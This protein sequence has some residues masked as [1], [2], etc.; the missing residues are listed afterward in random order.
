MITKLPTLTKEFG[1]FFVQQSEDNCM[2]VTWNCLRS[3]GGSDVNLQDCSRNYFMED[4]IVVEYD[5]GAKMGIN[6]RTCPPPH[7]SRSLGRK[8]NYL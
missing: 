3:Y 7:I 1:Y 4:R 5:S 8:S 6:P 2:C